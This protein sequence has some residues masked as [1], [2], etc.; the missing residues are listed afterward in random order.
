MR[1]G[2]SSQKGSKFE[3][4]ICRK[5]S[6]WISNGKNVNVFWRTAASGARAT[7]AAKRGVRIKP[8]EGDIAAIDE[9]GTDFIDTF[10]I[11]C[12]HRRDLDLG[13]FLCGQG[14]YILKVWRRLRRDSRKLNKRPMMIFKNN[15]CDVLLMLDRKGFKLIFGGE[16]DGRDATSDG[17]PDL[18]LISDKRNAYIVTLDEFCE[19]AVIGMQETVH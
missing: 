15:R 1:P 9:M 3:R 12:K 8:H 14:G 18:R 17:T 13:S 16:A 7:T 10:L 6:L 11:E 19:F 4:D 2:G 5:L